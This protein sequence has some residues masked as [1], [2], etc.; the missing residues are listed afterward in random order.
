MTLSATVPEVYVSAMN[1]FFTDPYDTLED[2]LNNLKSLKINSYPEDNITD[3]CADILVND[4]CLESARA[5]N[6][7]NLG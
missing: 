2:T 1:T 6:T 7:E 4:D 5:F 3:L